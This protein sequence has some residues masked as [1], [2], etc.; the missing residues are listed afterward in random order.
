MHM[1]LL[2]LICAG[3][4]PSFGPNLRLPTVHKFEDGFVERTV[5]IVVLPDAPSLPGPGRRWAPDNARRGGCYGRH[6]LASWLAP[7]VRRR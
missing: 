2:V 7:A 3:L 5:A 4:A 1:K 6:L